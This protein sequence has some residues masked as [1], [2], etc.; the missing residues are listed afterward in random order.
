MI[1]IDI[2]D[3]TSQNMSLNLFAVILMH[4]GSF[5]Q[6]MSL[7]WELTASVFHH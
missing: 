2:L 7:D 5:I 6:Q 3:Y 4:L 1:F